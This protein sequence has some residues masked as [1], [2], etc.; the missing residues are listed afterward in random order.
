[1]VRT[2][3]LTAH[4][5][6]FKIRGIVVG[7]SLVRPMHVTVAVQG[8]RPLLCAVGLALGLIACGSSATTSVTG[9]TPVKCQVTLTNSSAS[10]SSGGGSG[11]VTVTTSREC[12]WSASASGSWIH[13]NGGQSGQG[14]GSVAYTVDANGAASRRQANVIVNDQSSPVSQDAAPCR[15]D[16]SAPDGSLGAAGGQAAIDIRTQDE[17]RWTAASNATWATIAPA[18]GQGSSTLALTA[19]PN[20]G[21]ERTVTLTIGPDSVVLRQ[22][23]PAAPAPAPNP[24]SPAP[25]PSPGPSPAPAP[26]PVP[27]PPSPT[28]AP[29]PI[30]D[31]TGRVSQLS[32]RCPTISFTVSSTKVQTTTATSFQGGSCKDVS[33]K[34]TVSVHG[35]QQPN[36]VVIAGVVALQR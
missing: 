8:W 18:S 13:I 31:L 23:S 16:V 20:S 14:D 34:D 12:S 26:A 6:L 5:A 36:G 3:V 35:E 17:C 9:P 22:L 29:N 15:Y 27:P 28:P 30:V 4:V 7:K 2:V 1:M 11:I 32:G 19:A 25:E 10:F 24:P 33:N 21:P